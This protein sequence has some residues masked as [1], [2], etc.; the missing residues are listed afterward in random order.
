[1]AWIIVL[2]TLT[3][4]LT[5]SIIWQ[6][7]SFVLILVWLLKVAKLRL[8]SLHLSYR[9][10][11]QFS[12]RQESYLPIRAPVDWL[13]RRQSSY[14]IGCNNKYL[15]SEFCI[16]LLT[17]RSTGIYLVFTNVLISAVAALYL[18]LSLGRRTHNISNYCMPDKASLTEPY[19]CINENGDLA[20]CNKGS[21]NNKWKPPRTHHCSVCGVCRLE[22]DHHCPW[23][24]DLSL[25]SI[26]NY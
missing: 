25:N 9:R 14:L 2:E 26:M 18:S 15:I 16:Y 8:V 23:V 22:F 13:I 4:A 11:V 17:R 12:H 19:Q 3:Q 24:A 7:F 21:C 10:W 6:V 5:C 20:T 1:M